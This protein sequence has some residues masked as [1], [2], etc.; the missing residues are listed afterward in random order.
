[1]IN[2][3]GLV[4][5]V[6]DFTISSLISGQAKVYKISLSTR[7]LTLS[8]NLK[9]TWIEAPKYYGLLSTDVLLSKLIV[10]S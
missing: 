4:T 3:A 9:A 5:Y 7:S 10:S 8:L 6:V 1:M 2:F